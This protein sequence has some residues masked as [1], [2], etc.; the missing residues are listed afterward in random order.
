MRHLCNFALRITKQVLSQ[1]SYTTMA[2]TF[3]DFKTFPAARK[4]P[5]TT[6]YPLRC[7][8]CVKT[9]GARTLLCQT[10]DISLAC[11]SVPDSFPSLVGAAKPEYTY[12]DFGCALFGLGF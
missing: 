6:F 5:I 11:P 2:G 12:D 9:P 4:L 10:P 3:A 8:D 7:Q 1:L